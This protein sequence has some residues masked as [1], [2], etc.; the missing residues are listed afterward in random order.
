MPERLGHHR[1]GRA[2]RR[3]V[4]LGD[5]DHPSGPIRDRAGRRGQVLHPGDAVAEVGGEIGE[6]AFGDR[7]L[8]L[9]TDRRERLA[10]DLLDFLEVVVPRAHLVA[11]G[12]VG[13]ARPEPRLVRARRAGRR[14]GQVAHLGEEGD[15]VL[16]RRVVELGRRA[17]VGQ[18]QRLVTGVLLHP[19]DRHL[20]LG[21]AAGRCLVEEGGRLAPEG[22]GQLDDRRQPRLAV[23]VLQLRQVRRRPA[24]E[25]AQVPERQ[26]SGPP[27]V[28]QLLSEQPGIENRAAHGESLRLLAKK[29]KESNSSDR[30]NTLSFA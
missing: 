3:P 11:H 8:A 16:E 30:Q 21:A 28:A 26:S 15:E 4:S 7:P 6:V 29:R 19:G 18:P 14:R 25:V 22:L 5:E 27:V 1:A 12:G 9:V 2:D 20:E 24:D 23:A 10:G 17:Q 13:P